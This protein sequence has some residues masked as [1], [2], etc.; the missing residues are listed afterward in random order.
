MVVRQA[1]AI[2]KSGSR[3]YKPLAVNSQNGR[4][5]NAGFMTHADIEFRR[6]VNYLRSIDN[7]RIHLCALQFE[8]RNLR[9]HA[10]PAWITQVSK[11]SV[12]V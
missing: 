5:G 2:Y 7:E 11:S 3:G 9:R 8:N 1:T 12:Y 6:I 4:T 10:N